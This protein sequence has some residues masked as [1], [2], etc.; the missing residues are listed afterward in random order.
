MKP[1]H[2]RAA[3]ALLD[4]SAQEL[5]DLSEVSFS[6]VR[7]LEADVISVKPESI[8]RVKKALQAKGIRFGRTQGGL[9]TVGLA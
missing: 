9:I 6:T 7:R 3:R 5:A 4:L 8:E 2:F 1:G